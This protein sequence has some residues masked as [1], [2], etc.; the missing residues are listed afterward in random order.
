MT[1]EVV[2]LVENTELFSPISQVNYEYYDTPPLDIPQK[3]SD[4]IQCLC[5]SKE[6]PLGQAQ[7]PSLTDYADGIDTMAFALSLKN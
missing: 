7:F 1:N 6:I 2:L 5:G 4:K 3:F